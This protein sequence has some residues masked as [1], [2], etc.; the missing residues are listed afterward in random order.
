MTRCCVPKKKMNVIYDRAQ[1]GDNI[2]EEDIRKLKSSWKE[3]VTVQEE[4][5][6]TVVE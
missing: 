3:S 4:M 1:N 6:E 2:S 5:V